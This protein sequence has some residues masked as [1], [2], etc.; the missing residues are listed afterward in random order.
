M[1]KKIRFFG[2]VQYHLI[3]KIH[4]KIRIEISN[5]IQHRIQKCIPTNLLVCFN[6]STNLKFLTMK[7][8]F[9]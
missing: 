9:D 4:Q 7:Y 6:Q 2:F 8:R 3:F 5:Q 1:T